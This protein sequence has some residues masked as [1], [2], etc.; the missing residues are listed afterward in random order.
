L[1]NTKIYGYNLAKGE[2]MQNKNN[3]AKP[4]LD[5]SK[6]QTRV[7]LVG[8]IAMA[9]M[10]IAPE[11]LAGGIDDIGKKADDFGKDIKGLAKP[12]GIVLMIIGGVML[13][14]GDKSK[15]V[16]AIGGVIM[17]GAALG[18]ATTFVTSALGGT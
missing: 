8:A 6:P 3:L 1:Q 11:A 17:A 18:I 2:K 13:L 16:K 4:W 5:L 15:I 7:I 9:V 10:L 14:F 12:V